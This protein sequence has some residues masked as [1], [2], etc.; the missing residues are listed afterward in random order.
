MSVWK[1][2]LKDAPKD[3]PILVRHHEWVSP[4]VVKFVSDIINGDT[5]EYWAYCEQVLNDITGGVAHED[6]K[7]AEWAYIPG[8]GPREITKT[9]DELDEALCNFC[10]DAKDAYEPVDQWNDVVQES[11]R[12]LCVAYNNWYKEHVWDGR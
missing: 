9:E 4:Q 1:S 5:I 8:T 3:M 11:F 10:N 7:F 6:E 2:G 12:Q